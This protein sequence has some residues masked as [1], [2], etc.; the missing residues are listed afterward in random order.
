[1]ILNNENVL[2]KYHCTYLIEHDI[3]TSL[4]ISSWLVLFIVG[5]K[6]NSACQEKS[7]M[8]SRGDARA[9]HIFPPFR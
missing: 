7:E 6:L 4:S 8:E 1:M 5:L 2:R 3:D 9:T